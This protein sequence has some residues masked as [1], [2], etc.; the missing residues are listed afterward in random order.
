MVPDEVP[1]WRIYQFKN[2]AALWNH[3]PDIIHDILF[4]VFVGWAS[5]GSFVDYYVD[6]IFALNKNCFENLCQWLTNL[7]NNDGFPSVNISKDQKQQFASLVLKE[8]A[9][10][11]KMQDIVREFSLA[12]SGLAGTQQAVQMSQVLSAWDRIGEK[13]QQKA[14]NQATT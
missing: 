13:V 1:E 12:C 2:L 11:R 5:F 10:K 4:F 3:L 7:V 14:D 9:N 6:V 8:R